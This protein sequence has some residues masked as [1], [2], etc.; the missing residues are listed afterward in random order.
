MTHSR[1]DPAAVALL[2]VL[3]AA[4]PATDPLEAG[5]CWLVT[6]RLREEYTGDQDAALR[7]DAAVLFDNWYAAYCRTEFDGY[8]S[9][10]GPWGCWCDQRVH[11]LT[12]ARAYFRGLV[13]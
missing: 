9:K 7:V 1:R 6:D 8:K 4:C 13:G 5:L 3:T 12:A 11:C 10:L 2:A